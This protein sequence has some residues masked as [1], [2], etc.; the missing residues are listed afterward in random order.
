MKIGIVPKVYSQYKDQ[1]EISVDYKLIKLLKLI[2]IKTTIIVLNQ[3]SN[4]RDLDLIVL[5]GGNDL[6]KLSKNKENRLRENLNNYYFKI[7]QTKKIP[8]IGICLGAQFIAQ[9]FKGKIIKKKQVGEHKVTFLKRSILTKMNVP[10]KVNSYHDYRIKKFGN[11]FQNLVFCP[12]KY[13]ELFY[14]SKR[15]IMGMMWHPER[16]K[17]FRKFDIKLIKKFYDFSNSSSRT[18]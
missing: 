1:I 9:K 7:S 16:Y 14:N 13:V 8:L 2:F 3:N 10:D 12:D 15:N 6:F 17:Q 4:Y 18:R 5:H 11:N